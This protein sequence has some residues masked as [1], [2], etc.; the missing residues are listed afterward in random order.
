MDRALGLPVDSTEYF[1]ACHTV[2]RVSKKGRMGSLRDHEGF[3][4]GNG[5]ALYGPKDPQGFQKAMHRG[6]YG[7]DLQAKLRKSS[8]SFN[9]QCLIPRDSRKGMIGI[10]L[11][12]P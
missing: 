10:P 6:P 12:I 4:K 11:G 2:A 7:P 1:I 9:L 3:Q 8:L 5:T